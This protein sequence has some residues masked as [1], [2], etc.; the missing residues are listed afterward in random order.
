MRNDKGFFRSQSEAVLC[1]DRQTMP[2]HK[3]VSH[4]EQAAMTIKN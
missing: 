2:D 3:P 1:S 4:S